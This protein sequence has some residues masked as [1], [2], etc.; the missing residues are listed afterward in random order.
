MTIKRFCDM[1]D[2]E[3]SRNYVSQRMK[4]KRRE[5]TAE[6]MFHKGST[7]NTGELCRKCVMEI[8]TQGKESK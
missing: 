7:C 4:I 5:F 8:L 3:I 2:G 1:C 6:V